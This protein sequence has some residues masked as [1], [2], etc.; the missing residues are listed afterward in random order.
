MGKILQLQRTTIGDHPILVAK[1]LAIREAIKITVRVK[2]NNIIVES[3]SQVTI[4]SIMDKMVAPKTV[5]V[6]V[7]DMKCILRILPSLIVIGQLI[8]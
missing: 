7:D 3:D 4:F 5:L 8:L 6:L 2:M 1:T